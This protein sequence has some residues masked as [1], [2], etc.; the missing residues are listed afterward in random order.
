M[1]S[2]LL[3][4]GFALTWPQDTDESRRALDIIRKVDGKVELDAKAR[5]VSLNL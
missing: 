1:K 4:L 2:A 3:L 5:V